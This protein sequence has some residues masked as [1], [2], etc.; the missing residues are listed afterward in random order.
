M[1]EIPAWLLGTLFVVLITGASLVGLVIVRRCTDQAELA[2]YSTQSSAVF[3]VVGT[4]Y[5]VMLAFVVIAVWE[6]LGAAEDRVSTEAAAL[7]GSPA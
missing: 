2:K 4:L 5:A 6:S 1:D 7:G 3:A